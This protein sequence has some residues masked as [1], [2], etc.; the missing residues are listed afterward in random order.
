MFKRI[1][2]ALLVL[3]A[4]FATAQEAAEA[5]E[6][7]GQEIILPAHAYLTDSTYG[8]KWDCD[9]GYEPSGDRCIAI[10]VP[11]NGY[12]NETSYGQPWSCE[13]GFFEQNGRCD[14]V[15]V[16]EHAYFDDS[17]HGKGWKCERGY[18]ASGLRCDAIDI[19]LNAHLD[20][21][22]N[23]WECDK[24]FQKSKDLCVLNN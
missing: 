12:L 22:G 20:R 2:L 23:S 8:S 16:P 5:P 15:V 24:N 9:R 3:T 1:T 11:D 6:P 4:G 10:A 14:A 21:S 7:L 19:P 17:T 13:R 18:A